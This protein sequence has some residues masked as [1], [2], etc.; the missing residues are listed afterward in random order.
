[1]NARDIRDAATRLRTVRIAQADGATWAQIAPLLG[2]ADG[3]AA[4]ARA[5]A[6]ER[7]L[8]PVA[9]MVAARKGWDAREAIDDRPLN[10]A[11]LIEAMAAGP[12]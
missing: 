10:C 2:C 6:L 1:V 11:P 7:S 5:R 9:G 3:K 8:R 4:K 12:E